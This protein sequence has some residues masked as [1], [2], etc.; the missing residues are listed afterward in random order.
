MIG[1]VL[2]VRD[3]G[4]SGGEELRE[5]LAEKGFQVMEVSSRRGAVSAYRLLRPHVVVLDG[6]KPSNGG[7]RTLRELKALEPA[8]SVIVV[9]EDGGP[10]QARRV[11]EEGAY[12]YLTRPMDYFYLEL[13]LVASFLWAGSGPPYGGQGEYFCA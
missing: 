12:E 11:M 10:E 13:A 6:L 7:L 9:A 5:F 2:V 1:K 4:A 3:N 8:A